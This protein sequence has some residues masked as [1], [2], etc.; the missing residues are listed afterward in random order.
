MTISI[1]YLTGEYP[2]ATDTFI[3][4]EVK[5]LRTKGLDIHTFSIRRTGD[6]HIVGSEQLEERAGTFCVLPPN[7][8]QLIIS[9]FLLLCQSPRRYLQAIKLAWQ[10][11]QHGL[12]GNLYQLFY[13]IEAGI[14]AAEVKR[15]KI[16]H[17]H[18]HSADSSGNVT[19]LASVMGDFTFSMTLHGPGLFFE[20]Y[21]WVLE[22]KFKRSLFCICISHFCRSQCMLFAPRKKW[23]KMYIVHC[24]LDLNLF[25]VVSHSQP[26]KKLLYVGRL[27]SVKG[28]PILFD[29]LSRLKST[30][31][32]FSLTLIGD[33]S[34]RLDLEKLANQLG[35]NSQIKF[36]G[37]K[38]QAEVREYLQKT[39]VFVLP[40][41]AE[42]VPVSLMESMA[43]GV[44][45]VATQVGGISELVEDG[46]TGYIVPPGDPISL[47][48][49]IELLLTD[50][51]LRNKL[52]Q[53]SRIKIEK[54]FNTIVETEKLYQIFKTALTKNS[55]SH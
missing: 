11:R 30:Y 15:R 45:V 6:E 5:A 54:E 4:R 14:I 34:E 33:G 26:G 10:T 24:S 22:E 39:D 16:T 50:I 47:A 32:N 13:F 8:G 42:G 53:A 31:P 28:L 40:S 37:Y 49:K 44:P 52:G 7:V 3:Q 36:V 12:K 55:H 41:F 19:M 46:V 29:S 25:K 27:A 20:P 23:A 51:Q 17:V 18:N 35:L 9:H 21:R 1:A 38:S 2:R 43:A 48:K